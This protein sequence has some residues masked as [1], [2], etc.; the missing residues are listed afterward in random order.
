MRAASDR[1]SMARVSSS[2][3]AANI[4]STR[5]VDALGK[6]LPLGTESDFEHSKP[7][8][9]DSA[10]FQHRRHGLAGQEANLDS[11]NDF[12]C[13]ARVDSCCRFPVAGV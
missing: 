6:L 13:V 7:L 5:R 1:A 4:R 2:R 12:R 8:Q 11:P 10:A 3:P 9:T